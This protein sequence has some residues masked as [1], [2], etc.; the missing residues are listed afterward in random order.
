MDPMPIFSEC[1]AEHKGVFAHEMAQ[2]IAEVLTKH[3]ECQISMASGVVYSI[4]L[5]DNGLFDT[6]SMRFIANDGTIYIINYDQIEAAW[7]HKGS[8]E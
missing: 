7:P 5:G 2:V 1:I 3:G 4:H 8:K 6:R